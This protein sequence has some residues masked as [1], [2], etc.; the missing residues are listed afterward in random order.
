VNNVIYYL[1]YHYSQM[2]RVCCQLQISAIVRN[3]S[4]AGHRYGSRY[5]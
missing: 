5:W 3:F 2:S 1:Y 4:R